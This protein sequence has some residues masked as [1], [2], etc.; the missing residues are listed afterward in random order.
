MSDNYNTPILSDFFL[1]KDGNGEVKVEIYI[2]NETVKTRLHNC[3]EYSVLQ[4]QSI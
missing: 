4:L 2:F 3:L 1:Y